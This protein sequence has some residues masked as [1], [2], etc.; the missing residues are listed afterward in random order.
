MSDRPLHCRT[1]RALG[2]KLA[3]TPPEMRRLFVRTLNLHAPG[4]VED[5]DPKTRKERVRQAIEESLKAAPT[6]AEAAPCCLKS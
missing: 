4:V 5:P 2:E 3:G 6:V 1:T